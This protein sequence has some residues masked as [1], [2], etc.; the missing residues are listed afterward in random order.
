MSQRG[1]K[2]ETEGELVLPLVIVL[3]IEPAEHE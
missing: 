3:L 1:T 2:A